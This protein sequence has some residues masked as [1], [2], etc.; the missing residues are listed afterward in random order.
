LR[1]RDAKGATGARFV[2]VD[3][4][5]DDLRTAKSFYAGVLGLQIAEEQE[6][7][8]AE[9]EGEGGF[10]CL[11]NKGVESYPS[12][13]K[14]LLLFE[15]EDLQTSIAAIGRERWVRVENRGRF[16]TIPRGTTRSSVESPK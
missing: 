10:I 11:E 9:F 15:V 12:K 16:C 14:A 5:F 13:D 1:R 3:L 4:C 8:Q 6:G 2:G 7:H